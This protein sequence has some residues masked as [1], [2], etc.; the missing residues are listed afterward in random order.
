MWNVA[1]RVLAALF[2]GMVVCTALVTLQEREARAHWQQAR[3]LQG[4]ASYD[5]AESDQRYETVDL[6]RARRLTSMQLVAGLGIARGAV[7]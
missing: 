1:Q 2:F 6:W 7:T 4:T 3:T 5:A